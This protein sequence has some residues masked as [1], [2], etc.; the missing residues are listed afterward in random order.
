MLNR[1]TDDK[2]GGQQMAVPLNAFVNDQRL[3]GQSLER[4]ALFANWAPLFNI[5]VLCAANNLCA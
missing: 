5:R 2:F 4:T 1:V 3:N